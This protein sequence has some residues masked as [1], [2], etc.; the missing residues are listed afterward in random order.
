M[1]TNY[2]TS[3]KLLQGEYLYTFEKIEMYISTENLPHYVCI[4]I[5]EEIVDLLLSAQH[6]LTPIQDV[7][8]NDIKIFCEQIIQNFHPT[9]IHRFLKTMLWTRFYFFMQ[10]YLIGLASIAMTMEMEF[11]VW[12]ETTEI[13]PFILPSIIISFFVLC[14][15]YF[16]KEY[17]Y[18]QKW[19]TKRMHSIISWIAI[20]ITFCFISF[21][22]SKFD[23]LIYVPN[24]ILVPSS[25]IIYYMLR[26]YARKNRKSSFFYT[27]FYDGTIYNYRKCHKKYIKK[28]QKKLIEPKEMKEWIKV[29]SLKKLYTFFLGC[30]VTSLLAF[31]STYVNENLYEAICF[32][33]VLL[34]S[35]YPMFSFFLNIYSIDQD[36]IQ[37]L[38]NLQ[39]DIY[40]DTLFKGQQP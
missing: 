30:L 27:C 13:S 39:T 16:M 40:D 10:G 20:I 8:G 18:H 26:Y 12:T 22:Y 38:E 5:L 19:Y 35:M 7:I 4:E 2:Q 31:I 6:D 34:C 9:I 15:D 21:I 23:Y 17:I 3:S 37:S 25:F 28:C 33:L 24:F 14:Y 29:Y 36:V 11:S 32:F 1:S